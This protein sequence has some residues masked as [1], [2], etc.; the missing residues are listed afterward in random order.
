MVRIYE[1]KLQINGG[2]G[3]NAFESNWHFVFCLL[4]NVQLHP[5]LGEPHFKIPLGKLA[6]RQHRC[7][8]RQVPKMGSI[9]KQSPGLVDQRKLNVHVWVTMLCVPITVH[10]NSTSNLRRGGGVCCLCWATRHSCSGTCQPL[11]PALV[12]TTTLVPRLCAAL[13]KTRPRPDG[14]PVQIM[15]GLNRIGVYQCAK[16][17]FLMSPHHRVCA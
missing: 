9:R 13:F 3:S 14:F 5:G 11:L 4:H 7:A 12:S 1:A 10:T 2:G 8:T 6:P 15:R 16:P 17:L